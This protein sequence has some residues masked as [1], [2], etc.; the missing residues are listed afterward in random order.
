V[1]RA[2][3]HDSEARLL[4][5]MKANDALGYR[6][7]I[8]E[9]APRCAR[10]SNDGDHRGGSSAKS[11]QRAGDRATGQVRLADGPEHDIGRSTDGNSV[12]LEDVVLR[13]ELVQE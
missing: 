13:H 1:G 10:R 5:V 9:L 2:L 8:A 11:E 12:P 3:G 7:P 6:N 4:E